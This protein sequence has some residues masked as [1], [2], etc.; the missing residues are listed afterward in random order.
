MTTAMT[1]SIAGIFNSMMFGILCNVNWILTACSVIITVVVTLAFY[2]IKFGYFDIMIMFV[3]CFS[4][5]FL[6]IGL[7]KIEK[8]EKSEFL[9]MA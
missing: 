6:F 5:F 1:Q 4:I 7:Y 9:Q 3:V 2:Q 8:R